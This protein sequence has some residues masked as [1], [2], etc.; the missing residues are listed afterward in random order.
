[1]SEQKKETKPRT[2]PEKCLP[3]R[4]NKLGEPEADYDSKTKSITSRL[5]SPDQ[6]AKREKPKAS[7]N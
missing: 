4:R 5:S 7:K 3:L 1:M 2:S 6:Y